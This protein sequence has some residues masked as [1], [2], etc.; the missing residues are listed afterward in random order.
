MP[1]VPDRRGRLIELQVYDYPPHGVDD[2]LVP[3]H[4]AC[5]AILDRLCTIR[6]QQQ[7]RHALGS[8]KPD[9]P[10]RFCVAFA[11]CRRRNLDTPGFIVGYEGGLEWPHQA[12]GATRYWSDGWDCER[13]GEVGRRSL[14]PQAPK[15][16][17]LARFSARHPCFLGTIFH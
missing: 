4:E 16:T 2:M 3:V 15:L 17:V 14:F 6:Q 11:E 13:G 5:L 9:T 12:Y 7:T 1:L 8:S 10:E